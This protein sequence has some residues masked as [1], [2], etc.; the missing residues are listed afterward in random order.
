[1][2]NRKKPPMTD[3]RDTITTLRLL[4]AG[5]AVGDSLG[6]TSEFIPQQQIPRLYE[7]WRRRGWPFAQVGGGSFGWDA[8]DPTDDTEMA[9]AMVES[10]IENQMTFDPADVA[11]RFVVWLASGPKDIGATTAT[12]SAKRSQIAVTTIS[13][14]Y[15]FKDKQQL[16]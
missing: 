10:F 6:S 12:C 9:W 15:L 7:D 2:A 11:K 3:Q 8:G 4:L 14:I 5:L 13:I 1:M 16:G